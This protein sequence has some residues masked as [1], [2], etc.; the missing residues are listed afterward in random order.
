M[1]LRHLRYFVAVAQHRHFGRAA[2]H[3]NISQPPLSQQIR[4]LERELGA[5]L[6]ARTTRRVELTEAGRVFYPDAVAILA[7]VDAARARVQALAEGWSG[8]LRI[9]FAGS[10]SYRQLPQVARLVQHYLP[11]VELQMSSEMLTPE[12]EQALAESR[13]DLGILRPPVRV[14]G[15]ATRTLASEPL[16]LAAP[17]GHP[18][19][20]REEIS[21]ADL[22]GEALLTYPGARSVVAARVA[23]TLREAGT[24]IGRS[25][26]VAQTSSMIALV[27][28]GMGVALVPDSVRALTMEGVTYLPVTDAG[29]VDLA[30]AWREDE[31]SPLIVRFRDLL[32]T[33][34][35]TNK[36]EKAA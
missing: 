15:I 22:A 13:L 34:L 35:A 28:A 18:L 24:T 17:A 3:L 4:Q 25:R 12:Q 19:S 31:T 6:F 23:E 33:H 10:A 2:D 11:H 14:P 9:G 36:H 21:V 5:E 7:E 20:A 1:E 16:I 27:A 29:T 8:L 26:D 32:L 30:L